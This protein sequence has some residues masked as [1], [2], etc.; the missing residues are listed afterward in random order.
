MRRGGARPIPAPILIGLTALALAGC[1]E[2]AE[3]FKDKKI[4]EALKLEKDAQGYT[5]D[6]DPFCVLSDRFFH[7]SGEVD[8][9]SGDD[10]TG[11]IVASRAGNVAVEGVPSFFGPDCKQ[12]ARKRLDDLDP[13]AG[14]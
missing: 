8:A 14:E 4:V 7:D 10:D 12:R 13:P 11:V 1:G 2:D 6:G 5:L 3:S 9:A